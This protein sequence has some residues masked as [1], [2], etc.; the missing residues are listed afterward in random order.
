MWNDTDTPLAYLTTFR[1]YG[2]RLHGDPRGS[3]NRFRNQYGTRRLPEEQDWLEINASRMKREP[4]LLDG[5]RR[6]CVDE[7]IRE[8]CEKRNWV[9]HAVNVR[10]NHAHS[11]AW[12]GDKS[13]GTALNAFKANS[14]RLMRERGY[15]Q[16][17]RSPWADKGS[18]RYLWNEDSVRRAI[19][20]VVFGQGDELPDF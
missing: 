10:T 14:T 5:L 9:L 12:I 6:S 4:V 8:T 19:D 7:A 1:T 16:S 2:T 3:V 11:V 18:T 20:Y 17:D 15:W 13:P